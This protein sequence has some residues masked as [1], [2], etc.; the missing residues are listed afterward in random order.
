MQS[1][2]WGAKSQIY[3][4]VACTVWLAA[5]AVLRRSGEGVRKWIGAEALLLLV[6]LCARLR[7]SARRAG[8]FS[9]VFG[10][11]AVLL[12][13]PAQL[14]SAVQVP[15]ECAAVGYTQNT[16]SSNS[17]FSASTVDLS[18]S[19]RSG[20]K[21]YP[22]NWFSGWSPKN[23]VTLH[24]D[25]SVSAMG[26]T[27]PGGQVTSAA[28]TSQP[29]YFVG[30]AFG[31]GMCVD[32]VLAFDQAKIDEEQGH[33]SFWT[34]SVEHLDGQLKSQWPGQPAGFE[35]FAEWDILESYKVRHP[36]F[37]SSWIE[38]YGFYNRSCPGRVYCS[39]PQ[40][41]QNSRASYDIDP[42]WTKGHRVTGVWVPATPTS[43][44]YV[45]AFVDG[46]PLAAPH[47]W[48]MYSDQ[49][50]PPTMASPWRFGIID[51]QHQ[52]LIFGGAETPIRVISVNVFQS[53]DKD[54]IHN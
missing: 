42:D 30:T 44:G 15:P 33:P 7:G 31:G 37:L 47:R 27:G 52:V 18:Q 28:A 8:S 32:A 50:P 1:P 48:K 16:F 3:L 43:D 11:G 53:S 51:K 39:A 6:E 5:R 10:F 12:V 54:N 49:A 17:D 46:I 19:G 2:D 26:V 29:P 20:F 4:T 38:W 23:T 34:M 13:A 21:W 36:G 24:D 25:G 9:R 14:A 22:W 35:H 40:S 45:Q 41:F